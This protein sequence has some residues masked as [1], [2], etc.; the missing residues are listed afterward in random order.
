MGRTQAAPQDRLR[1][2]AGEAG[3][4]GQTGDPEAAES[5]NEFLIRSEQVPNVIRLEA[6]DLAK[7]FSGVPALRG[8]SLAVEAG[9]VVAVMGENGAGKSTLMRILSGAVR[10]DSGTITWGTGRPLSTGMVHQE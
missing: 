5:A 8:A 4:S 9:E 2:G 3:G 6:H 10:Q 1:C 7:S